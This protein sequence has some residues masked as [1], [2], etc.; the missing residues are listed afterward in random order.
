MICYFDGQKDFAD[1]HVKDLVTGGRL[2][3]RAGGTCHRDL[4][5]ERR[6]AQ[7]H[8][9]PHADLSPTRPG[10]P[11]WGT[12]QEPSAAGRLRKLE[13]QGTRPESQALRPCGAGEVPPETLRNAPAPSAHQ[14]VPHTPT[15]PLNRSHDQGHPFLPASPA[16]LPGLLVQLGDASKAVGFCS[17]SPAL[18]GLPSVPSALPESLPA[19]GLGRRRLSFKE[20]SGT[21]C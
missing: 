7:L 14:P 12:G 3:S 19:R 6:E 2:A 15:R 11:R 10:E 13:T 17:L 9:V 5:G 16:P 4:G 18:L 20:A 8:V 1:S 21:A